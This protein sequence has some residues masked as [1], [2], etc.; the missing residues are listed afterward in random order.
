[1]RLVV[2]SI[3]RLKQGPE[4]ELAELIAL[5]EAK[6]LSAATARTVAAEL[7]APALT[8]RPITRDLAGAAAVYLR[9]R[10]HYGAADP[11]TLTGLQP[12]WAAV[13]GTEIDLVMDDGRYV[14]LKGGEGLPVLC[15][16]RVPEPKTVKNRLH[17]DV[18]VEDLAAATDRIVALGGSWPDR[19]ERQLEG[20]TWRT[21]ADPEGNEFDIAVG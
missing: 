3:G 4:Q 2:V 20:F 11:D 9:A 19:A 18:S 16:Q 6:G 8:G 21:M 14:F 5:Y 10:T 15:F 17:V 13:L 1:M 7:T 12:I